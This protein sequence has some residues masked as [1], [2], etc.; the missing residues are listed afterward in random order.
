MKK[1]YHKYVFDVE[2]RAF[3]GQF[4]EMYQSEQVEDFDSWHQDD[5]RHLPRKI[6]LNTIGDMN[7]EI[8]VDLGCGKG[9]FTHI[10]KRKNNYVVGIDISPTAINRAEV[11]YPD[12]DFINMDIND[13]DRL[14][15]F[16]RGIEV[17]VTLVCA[18]EILSY[19]PRWQD[20]LE[21]L[22]SYTQYLV[23]GLDIPEN[24]IGFVKDKKE[25]YNAVKRNYNII[26]SISLKMHY[27]MI[28]FAE[29]RQNMSCSGK[30][31]CS[32]GS[33]CPD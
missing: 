32:T 31:I 1:E 20:I 10:L 14:N 7:F 29:S 24:P 11:R 5:I 2:N 26:E 28:I 33:D 25:L 27:H 30:S 6:L 15:E 17:P 8:V 13:P 12:I 3:V 23:I 18:R 4:D 21:M 16:I 19:L 9:S 22:S